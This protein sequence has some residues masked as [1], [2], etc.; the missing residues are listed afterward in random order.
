MQGK[1]KSVKNL[2]QLKNALKPGTDFLITWHRNFD[3]IGQLRQVNIANTQGIY[4]IIPD[5][6]GSPVTTA[7]CGKG[8]W[9]PFRKAS[10]WSFTED[11]ASLYYGDVHTPEQL[12]ITIKLQEENDDE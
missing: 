7:N 8:T 9:L 5:D 12:I 1:S 10:N 11:G 3:N 2:S 4:S 6:P